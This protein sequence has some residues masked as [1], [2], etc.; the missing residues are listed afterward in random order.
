MITDYPEVKKY[1][2]D[3][4]EKE[5]IKSSEE[6]CGFIIDGEKFV[7]CKNMHPDPKNFFLIDPKDCIWEEN[8]VLFHSHPKHAKEE[9]FSSWDLENQAYSGFPMLLYSVNNKK[10]YFKNYDKFE[11]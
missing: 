6:I 1:I 8:V 10:F 5:S 11:S 9:G 3:L 2:L 4:L 7:M